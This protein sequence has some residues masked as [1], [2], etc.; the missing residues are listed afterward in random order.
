MSGT[1]TE[2]SAPVGG[3]GGILP[4]GHA[5][6]TAFVANPM[7]AK[8]AT[9]E[10][11]FGHSN[12]DVFDG[13]ALTSLPAN[14]AS[15]NPAATMA[16][17]VSFE[18]T[19]PL[20]FLGLFPSTSTPQGLTHLL[21]VPCVCP[22]ILGTLSPFDAG[23]CAY[24]NKVAGGSSP[25][26]GFSDVAFDPHNTTTMI[27]IPDNPNGYSGTLNYHGGSLLPLLA[28]GTVDTKDVNIPFM[29]WVPPQYVLLFLG[30]RFAPHTIAVAGITA[31]ENNG[32]C[33]CAHAQAQAQAF[34]DWL[35]A[36]MHP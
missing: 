20:V 3:S 9:L 30:Y 23:L 14:L 12:N 7:L 35:M 32:A 17:L 29:T 13:M 27:T 25:T 15:C 5:P 21:I 24:S 18:P 11:W 10:G 1:G 28:S 16:T 34:V 26:V 33:V 22:W 6:G 31:V 8:V 36:L 19:A 4:G 2:G